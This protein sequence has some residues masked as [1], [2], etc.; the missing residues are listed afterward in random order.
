MSELPGTVA[1]TLS[2]S[3]RDGLLALPAG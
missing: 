3:A 1:A 2:S